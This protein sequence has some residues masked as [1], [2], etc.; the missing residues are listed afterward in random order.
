MSLYVHI[1]RNCKPRKF[2][3]VRVDQVEIKNQ[4]SGLYYTLCCKNVNGVPVLY[5]SDAGKV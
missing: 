3:V 5:L 4:S 2:K 1:R